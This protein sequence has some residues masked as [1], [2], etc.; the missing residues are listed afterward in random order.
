[1]SWKSE[2]VVIGGKGKWVGGAL[3]FA[4]KEEAL[5]NVE[6]LRRRW[7]VVIDTRVTESEDPVNH[8]GIHAWKKRASESA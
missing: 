7:T 8:A 5:A 4:T 3:R 6:D 2:V 1:M